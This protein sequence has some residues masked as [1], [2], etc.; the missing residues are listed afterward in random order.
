MSDEPSPTDEPLT[1]AELNAVVGG[2]TTPCPEHPGKDTPHH[3]VA[4]TCYGQGYI[5]NL[6]GTA[7]W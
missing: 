5:K 7:E 2:G 4:G 1:A 6:G 3:D